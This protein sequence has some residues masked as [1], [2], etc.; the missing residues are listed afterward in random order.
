MIRFRFSYGFINCDSDSHCDGDFVF[1]TG[2]DSH[3]NPE[4]TSYSK[5]FLCHSDSHY[6]S[7]SDSCL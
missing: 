1:D 6:D 3:C 4:S 5:H 7:D 2:S